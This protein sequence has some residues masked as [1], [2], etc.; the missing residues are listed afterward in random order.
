MQIRRLEGQEEA[1]A[2]L[3]F[4]ARVE[5]AT[6]VPPLGESKFVDLGG[7][8]AGAGF[9]L[10][11]TGIEAYLHLLYHEP[12]AVWEMELAARP[13]TD[14]G[15]IAALIREAGRRAED[16]M[17]WW[18]FG[19]SVVSRFARAEFAT[20]RELQKLA[21]PVPPPEPTVL[22]A[23]LEIHPFRPGRDEEA[24]LAV[25][26]AAF[27]GHPENGAWTRSDLEA[28]K[29]RSWFDPDGFRLA[30]LG[31]ELAGFCW[32][33]RHPADVGEIHVI[34]VHPAL[35]GRGIGRAIVVEGLWYL[36]GAGCAS[37]MLYVDTSNRS[38]LELYQSLGFGVERVDV[39]VEVPKGWPHDAQ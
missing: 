23:G 32:T 14:H 22:P 18:T 16:R 37:G 26:N 17:L 15:A 3:D 34:G 24:W 11:G 2:V 35:Q 12:S 39:C 31:E 1:A 20:R 10:E 27:A 36:A 25:N 9:V 6:G 5:A 30:W 21:G 29:N 4:I 33:K 28:R 38:A 8:L 7:P 19:E 13:G